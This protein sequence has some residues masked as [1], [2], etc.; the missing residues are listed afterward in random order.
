MPCAKTRPCSSLPPEKRRRGM[1][2]VPLSI[3]DAAATNDADR[4]VDLSQRCDTVRCKRSIR[5]VEAEALSLR[6]RGA[7]EIPR[8]RAAADTF[9]PVR[10]SACWTTVRSACDR[11]L[12]KVVP[13]PSNS[14]A[15]KGR[16]RHSW[17]M[18]SARRVS[19]LY[20]AL[21]KPLSRRGSVMAMAQASE[22]DILISIGCPFSSTSPARSCRLPS[23]QRTCL[24]NW[25]LFSPEHLV[26]FSE[27]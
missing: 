26:M 18:P 17:V 1:Q 13:T 3:D 16:V 9:P 8:Y 19:S 12:A 27:T 23:R 22:A 11:L 4:V 10:A 14:E 2:R 21:S 7:R 25:S 6:W 20:F 24:T 5:P 15:G